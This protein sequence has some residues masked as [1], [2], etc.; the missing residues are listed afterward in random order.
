MYDYDEEVKQWFENYLYYNDDNIYHA[1]N[2]FI[3]NGYHL[4]RPDTAAR[5]HAENEYFRLRALC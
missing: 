3:S 4:D 1:E 2:A 5:L